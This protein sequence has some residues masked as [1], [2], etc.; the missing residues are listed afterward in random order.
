MEK[1]IIITAR[2]SRGMILALG[3]RGPGFKS[4]TSPAAYLL[5]L[6]CFSFDFIYGTKF[7]NNVVFSTN[8]MGIRYMQ[9][10]VLFSDQTRI[11]HSASLV[12]FTRSFSR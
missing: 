12:K 5:F 6:Y 3:A 8:I 9:D 11:N 4:R 2:W 1:F 7:G 10:T